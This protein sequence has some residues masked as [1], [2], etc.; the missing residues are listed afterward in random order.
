MARSRIITSIDLGTDK[1][2]TLISQLDELTQQLNIVGVSVVPSRGMKRS[3]II[4]LEQVIETLTE[5]IDA[6]ERMAGVPISTAFVAVSGSHIAS[7]NSKGVVAVASPTHEITRDDVARVIDAARAVSLPPEKEILHV[8]PRDFTVDSQ[9]G[10]KDPVGMTGIRLESEAHIITGMTTSLRN[11]GKCIQDVGLQVEG[12]V[13]A[14]LAAAEVTVTETEKELGVVLVDIGAGSTSICAYEDSSLVLSTAI[15]IG[16]RHITQ[17]IALGCRISLESAEKVKLALATE[18]LKNVQPRSG[19]SKTELQKRRKL[20]DELNLEKLG[21]HEGIEALSK[22]T[23]VEGIMVPRMKEMM[24][25]VGD[26]LRKANILKSVPAGLVLTGGGAATI[27]MVE[28]A[29]RTLDL[30]ARVG[31]PEQFKGIMSDLAKPAFATSLGLLAY[32]KNHSGG[33]EIKE[34]FDLT[35]LFKGLHFGSL[36]NTIGSFL[37]SLLP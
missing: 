24:G 36:P 17:D 13:F 29:R 21:I 22:K 28:V 4:N 8:V 7:Q 14:G 23:V 19:E 10:I 25:M 30:P 37:K 26:E 16:A 2:V 27:G 20:A 5:S 31:K 12:Y 33:H 11:L 34:S 32:G 3:Q 18:P 9:L 15:P 35:Q 6:A 1:C